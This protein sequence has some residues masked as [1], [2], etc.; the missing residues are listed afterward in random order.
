[1]GGA[2]ASLVF[3]HRSAE[4]DSI[5]KTGRRFQTPLFNLVSRASS[6][7]RVG[8]GIVVGKRLGGAVRRNRAKR[9]FRELARR[10]AGELLT[11]REFLVF[12]RR[13]AL[14]ARHPVLREAWMAALRHEGLLNS[15]PDRPCGASVSA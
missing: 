12:P 1:M 13:D 9:I 4:I 2:P 3:L 11:G 7:R 6:H 5:K 8:V 15:D 14:A 10:A